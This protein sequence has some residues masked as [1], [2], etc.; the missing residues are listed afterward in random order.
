MAPSLTA[1][2]LEPYAHCNC[3]SADGFDPDAQLH[4]G[5]D[6][7]AV[8]VTRLD[9][10]G[11]TLKMHAV[12]DRA[13]RAGQDAVE[14][15]RRNNGNTG[16]HHEIAHTAFVHSDDIERFKALDVVADVSPK[17]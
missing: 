6:A 15:A 11:F 2:F 17:L 9:A 3:S 13:V 10:A 4:Y 12:G 16:L 14:A 1:A 7:L 8:E 5:V